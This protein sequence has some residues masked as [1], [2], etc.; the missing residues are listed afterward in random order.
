MLG[1][2]TGDQAC[3]DVGPGRMLEPGDI[4]NAIST[5]PDWTLAGRRVLITAGPTIEDID[6]VRFIGNRSSGKMGF[7]L[8]AAARAAGADVRLIAGPCSLPTPPGVERTDV[9]S[10]AQ[11]H[12][13]V[14]NSVPNADVFIGVAAVADYTPANTDSTSKLKKGLPRQR[15]ELVATADIIADVAALDHRPYTVGFAAETDDVIDYAQDKLLRKGLDM[16]AANRVGVDGFR[17]ASDENEITLLFRDHKPGSDSP[18]RNLELGSGS[19]RRLAGRIIEQ[20]AGQLRKKTDFAD[21]SDKNTR[22]AAG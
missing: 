15:V 17:F 5:P 7:A 3:G 18:V 10:A 12:E 22:P 19:K 1:P 20:I 6:P 16:I 14:L 21:N 13:A 11:M 2:G 4:V 8:A 9:R